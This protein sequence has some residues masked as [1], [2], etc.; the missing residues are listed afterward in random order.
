M[1]EGAFRHVLLHG[2]RRSERFSSNEFAVCGRRITDEFRAG[3]Q[4]VDARA[5][6]ESEF[7]REPSGRVQVARGKSPRW[8][9]RSAKTR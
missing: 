3:D 7:A 5:A 9:F 8:R 2:H 4:Q 6:R 1:L